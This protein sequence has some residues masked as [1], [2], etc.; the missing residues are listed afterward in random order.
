MYTVENWCSTADK[1]ST[2]LIF[3][4]P[5]FVMVCMVQLLRIQSKAI[6]RENERGKGE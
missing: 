2:F 4:M 1:I 3:I 6:L 5:L